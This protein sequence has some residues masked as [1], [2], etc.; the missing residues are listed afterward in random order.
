MQVDPDISFF[1]FSLLMK[2]KLADLAVGVAAI[3]LAALL[4]LLTAK[5]R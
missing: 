3:E 1:H 5:P 2:K 4:G